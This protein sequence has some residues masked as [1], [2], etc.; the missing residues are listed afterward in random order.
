M[1]ILLL[2]RNHL[3]VFNITYQVLAEAPLDQS[4]ASHASRS[5]TS[6]RESFPCHSHPS[7]VSNPPSLSSAPPLL[8]QSL[9][10]PHLSITTSRIRMKLAL[11]ALRLSGAKNDLKT[12]H[13][14]FIM[15]LFK[16]IKQFPNYFIDLDGNI[17]RSRGFLK[18]HL[19][20]HGYLFVAL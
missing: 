3:K 13:I 18:S 17:L 2:W 15:V 1:S 8:R 14:Y 6:R 11:L 12:S 4:G 16:R 10:S 20:G 7:P 9:S 5:T 19:D